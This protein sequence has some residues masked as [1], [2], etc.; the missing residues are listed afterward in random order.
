[1]NELSVGVSGLQFT[2]LSPTSETR[3]RPEDNIYETASSGYNK[4][5]SDWILKFGSTWTGIISAAKLKQE[6]A[7]SIA[8]LDKLRE[9]M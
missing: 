8:E 2:T 7:E 9:Q 5:T 3:S 4:V 6:L 1:M